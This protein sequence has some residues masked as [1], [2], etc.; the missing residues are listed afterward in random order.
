MLK[1]VDAKVA[2][3][4]RVMLQ[5]YVERQYGIDED[6]IDFINILENR[7]EASLLTPYDLLDVA[8]FYF[9]MRDKY[10]NL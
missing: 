1:P 6:V 3:D 9:R 4:L 8:R 7:L 5:S 10:D 2:K